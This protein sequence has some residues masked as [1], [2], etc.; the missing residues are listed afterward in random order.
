MGGEENKAGELRGAFLVLCSLLL[1]ADC[2]H[3]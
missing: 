1:P 3:R 2:C